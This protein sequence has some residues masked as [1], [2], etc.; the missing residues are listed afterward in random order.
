MTDFADPASAGQP[1]LSRNK[2][3]ESTGDV[4][5]DEVLGHLDGVTDQP[6]DT[7][8]E[9]AEQVYRVLQSRLADLGQE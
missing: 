8:I 1:S 5:V 4:A 2:T 6:L 9:V 7:Q 3:G